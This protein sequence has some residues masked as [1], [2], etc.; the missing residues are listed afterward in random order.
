[1][2]TRSLA[3]AALLLAGCSVGPAYQRP[4]APAADAFRYAAV[5]A[6]QTGLVDKASR[7]PKG[8]LGLRAMGSSCGLIVAE[9]LPRPRKRPK[10]RMTSAAGTVETKQPHTPD[11]LRR[12]GN[13]TYETI[14]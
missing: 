4:T 3:L 2:T 6:R 14:T 10:L 7:A 9:P 5:V 13:H 12:V 11:A 8:K 1:M